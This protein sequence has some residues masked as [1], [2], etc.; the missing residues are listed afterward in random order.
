MQACTRI[1]DI[2]LHP[3]GL[4]WYMPVFMKYVS[5]QS[6]KLPKSMMGIGLYGTRELTLVVKGRVVLFLVGPS[7]HFFVLCDAF[8]NVSTSWSMT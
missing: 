6:M 4:R 7:G 2:Q 5:S 3:R 1:L 8:R